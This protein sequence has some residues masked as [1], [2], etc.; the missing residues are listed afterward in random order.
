MNMMTAQTSKTTEEMIARACYAYRGMI[1]NI[2]RKYGLAE[3]AADDLIQEVVIYIISY[4]R[5]Y[6]LDL[7]APN[8]FHS[9]VRGSAIQRAL[10]VCRGR[11][12]RCNYEFEIIEG[13][14]DVCPDE[15][16]DQVIEA[17]DRLERAFK[18]AGSAQYSRHVQLLL[19]GYNGWQIADLCNLNRN[20]SASRTKR[21]RLSLEE[22]FKDD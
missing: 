14:D 12:V 18:A 17:E 6:V 11:R 5:Q 16:P 20:S 7:S 19:D 22:E 15:L 13:L 10:N 2:A 21:I 3:D 1:A 8:K 9:L 4:H